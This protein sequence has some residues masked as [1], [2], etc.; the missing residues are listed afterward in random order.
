MKCSH[1]RLKKILLLIQLVFYGKALKIIKKNIVIRTYSLETRA[2]P[3]VLRTYVENQ[4]IL[5]PILLYRASKCKQ[6]KEQGSEDC[7]WTHIFTFLLDY[8]PLFSFLSN[9]TRSNCAIIGCN[10]SKKHK[11]S[12][13]KTQ[14]KESNYVDHKFLIFTRSDLPVQNLGDRYPNTI[15]LPN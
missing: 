4:A 13:Y 10:L 1:L 9:K 12:Q 11:L 2:E 6:T 15:E 8:C 3:A 5:E 14:N 7:L